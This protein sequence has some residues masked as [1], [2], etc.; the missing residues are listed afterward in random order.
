MTASVATG[1]HRSS[2]V[3]QTWYRLHHIQGPDKG[4]PCGTLRTCKSG[5]PK[6]RRC[7][8]NRPFRGR[9]RACVC[10]WIS[11]RVS[12]L[13]PRATGEG[14]RTPSCICSVGRSSRPVV[15]RIS[16]PELLRHL[17][18]REPPPSPAPQDCE[19]RAGSHGGPTRN[20]PGASSHSATT[21][22]IAK[23]ADLRTHPFGSS[24]R[25]WLCFLLQT[26]AEYRVPT[27]R[28]PSPGRPVVQSALSPR[29]GA[30]QMMG[31]ATLEPR[32][33]HCSAQ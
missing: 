18:H 21:C 6:C 7:R 11:W 12:M 9:G 29:T 17:R 10:P 33:E 3:V 19:S 30:S 20:G 24:I 26:T 32:R 2:D 4:H 22:A 15:S 25:A 14:E 28:R 1:R 27:V 8:G 31:G 13:T 23:P 5:A 16:S